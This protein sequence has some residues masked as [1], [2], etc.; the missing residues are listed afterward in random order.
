MMPKTL[1]TRVALWTVA[2]V[3]GALIL[4][5]AG[6]AWNLQK[7]LVKNLDHQIATEARNLIS[8]I[9]EQR[10][11]WSNREN[12]KAFFKEEASSFDYLEVRDAA[13]QVLYRSQSLGN[14]EVFPPQ[15]GGRPFTVSSGGHRLRFRVFENGPIR[16]ALGKDLAGVRQTLSGLASAYL[17][18]LPFVL[19]AVG[20]G[21][22][23]IAH[24]AAAPVKTITAQAEKISASDL[25]Q[26]LPA[27]SS[28]DEIGHLARVL[29]E[30][31]DRLQRSF[32]Q[33]TRFTSD[34]AHE[35]KTPLAL[36]RAQLETALGAREPGP[37]QRE[38]ISDL[39][40]QCSQLSQIVD[41]LM[42]LSRADDRHLAVA[43]DHVDLAALVHE[44]REDAEILAAHARLTLRWDLSSDLIVRGDLGLLRRGV[45]NLIDN[46]IK[47][48]RVGGSVVLIGS[49][50]GK[51]ALLTV[52]NTGTSIPLDAHEKIFERFYRSDCL[53]GE[54]LGGHGLGLSIARE[55]ARAHRGDVNLVRSEADWTEF[56]MVLPIHNVHA[57][58][59][60][61]AEP[62]KHHSP[63]P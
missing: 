61:P 43:T 23:W 27:P 50:D 45:M 14:R 57:N 16:F 58:R 4:F 6:A 39:I 46:A 20:G 32:E 59:L 13:G 17:F 19:V 60:E 44:L 7:D 48:N 8:E 5:G 9:Q 3:S 38:L 2:V 34:A 22:W 36:M 56:Q 47:Y 53:R 15:V 51:T 41:G 31:F 18:T 12:A 40:E 29:N 49:S 10:A 11:D 33:V 30:M 62:S 28:Q 63:G 21:G 54:G 1:R 35:L 52:R 37:A 55:I 25:H 24:R 26:R 42:F